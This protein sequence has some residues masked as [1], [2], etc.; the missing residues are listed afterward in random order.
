[1]F[2]LMP[3]MYYD[4]CMSSPLIKYSNPPH[5]EE[6]GKEGER[7]KKYTLIVTK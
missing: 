2:S 4:L 6:L 7:I 3:G 5:D 1:M